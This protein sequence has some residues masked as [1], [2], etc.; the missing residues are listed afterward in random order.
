MRQLLLSSCR[1]LEK[2]P[3][4]RRLVPSAS[5]SEPEG[6]PSGIRAQAGLTCYKKYGKIRQ[7]ALTLLWLGISIDC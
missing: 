6:Q 1:G 5:V 2:L 3:K 7:R 4:C